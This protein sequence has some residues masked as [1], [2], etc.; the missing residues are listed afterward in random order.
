MEIQLQ[1]QNLSVPSGNII[2]EIFRVYLTPMVQSE[3]FNY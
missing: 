2:D 3:N 1:P